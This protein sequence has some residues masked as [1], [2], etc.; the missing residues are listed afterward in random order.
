MAAF[1]LED[2]EVVL[3]RAR[4]WN[5]TVPMELVLTDRRLVLLQRDA[6]LGWLF[7]LFG[8]RMAMKYG[9]RVLR[10][11]GRTDFATA[12]VVGDRDIHISTKQDPREVYEVR[13]LQLT[14]KRPSEWA[15]RLHQWA[16]GNTAAA[17]LPSAKLVDR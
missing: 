5:T 16:A 1:A 10:R 15:D 11:I 6:V 17:T 13:S 14:V 12:V 7:G 2:G 8:R 4:V 3:E 9:G